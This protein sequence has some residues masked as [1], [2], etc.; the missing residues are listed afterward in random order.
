MR[1]L[2]FPCTFEKR[3]PQY[4]VPALFRREDYFDPE[5]SRGRCLGVKLHIDEPGRPT[6]SVFVQSFNGKMLAYCL[7]LRWFAS[8]ED[9]RSSIDRWQAA[10]LQPR[11]AAAFIGQETAC[12]VRKGSGLIS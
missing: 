11:Q 10:S 5:E 1:Y 4:E 2:G 3:R 9:A 12:N 7:D 8:N 6:Q